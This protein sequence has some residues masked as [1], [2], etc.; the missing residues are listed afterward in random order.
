MS[1]QV[2]YFLQENIEKI[3][4]STTTNYPRVEHRNNYKL[5]I[6]LNVDFRTLTREK[7]TAAFSIF[8]NRKKRFIKVVFGQVVIVS[9]GNMAKLFFLSKAIVHF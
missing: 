8:Q 5:F 6:L 4:F 7:T 3:S 9:S 2:G 1:D